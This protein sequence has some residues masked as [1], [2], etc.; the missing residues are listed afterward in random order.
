[1]APNIRKF[2]KKEAELKPQPGV[3]QLLL[4]SGRDNKAVSGTCGTADVYKMPWP[5][6]G[7][8]FGANVTRTV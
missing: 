3:A 2:W 6:C 1:M 8:Q 5:K 7:C 4:F